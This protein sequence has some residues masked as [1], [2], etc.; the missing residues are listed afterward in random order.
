MDVLTDDHE[1]AQVVRKWWSDNWKSLTLGIVI[2]LGGMIGYNQYKSY[3]LDTAAKYAYEMSQLQAKVTLSPEAAKKD[4]DAFLAEH[5]DIYGS[6]LSLDLAA[7]NSK[8]GKY[9]LAL[10]NAKFASENGGKLVAPNA[11]LVQAHVLAQLGKSEDAIKVLES[12]SEKAY[13]VEKFETLGD[14]YFATNNLDK[15]HDA[16]QSAMTSCEQKKISINPLLQMKADN[17]AK[18]GDAPAYKRAQALQ[19]VIAKSA[20]E[21]KK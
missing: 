18:E 12:I 8:A 14:I 21:I 10:E 16:Y 9:E 13:E 1:R 20:T 4:V 7:A 6:L 17:L 19:E 15:A 2:A 5:K 11:K 3:Q